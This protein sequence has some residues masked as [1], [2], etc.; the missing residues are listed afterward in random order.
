MELTGRNGVA[1]L[2]KWDGGLGGSVTDG[3]HITDG[4][5]GCSGT[6]G[7]H[8]IDNKGN[9]GVEGSGKCLSL[10]NSLVIKTGGVL[11][12][13]GRLGAVLCGWTSP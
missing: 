5:H 3:A 1:R 10:P 7:A 4:G 9:T 6:D 2:D 12:V 13:K 11:V 8:R